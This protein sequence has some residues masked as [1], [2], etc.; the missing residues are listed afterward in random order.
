M[1]ISSTSPRACGIKDARTFAASL[2]F[3]ARS[4]IRGKKYFPYKPIEGYLYGHHCH[5]SEDA[6]YNARPSRRTCVSHPERARFEPWR[7]GRER[8]TS[9]FFRAACF[10][11]GRVPSSPSTAP[12]SGSFCFSFSTGS[13]RSPFPSTRFKTSLLSNTSSL[14][15]FFFMQRSTWSHSTGVETVGRSL[16]R[17]EYTQIVVL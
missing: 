9:A 3:M 13:N 8:R 7:E 17:S 15:S 14:G 10:L 6:P 2:F 4:I 16:A 5:P 12:N 11:C 1:P